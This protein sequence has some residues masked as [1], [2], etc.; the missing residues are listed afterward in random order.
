MTIVRAILALA[1][2]QEWSLRQMD[3]KNAF[4][5]G[6]FKGRK[7]FMSPPPDMFNTPSSEVC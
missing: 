2:S 3:L 6:D 1:T 5:H 7:K 4:L